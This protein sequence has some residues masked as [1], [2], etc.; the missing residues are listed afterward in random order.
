MS[1]PTIQILPSLLAADMGNLEAASRASE[2]AGAD[3]LHIDVMDGHFVPNLSMGPD[4]VRMARKATAFPLSVHLMVTRPDFFADPFLDAGADLLLIH[5]EAQ[6][7]AAAVMKHVRSRGR[8]AGIVLNPET[9]LHAIDG[10]VDLADEVLFMTVHPGFGGQKFI[11]TQLENIRTLRKRK[12][13]LDISVDGGITVETAR[14]CAE[15]GANVF[16]AGTSIMR[17]PDMAAEIKKMR[18]ATEAALKT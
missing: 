3:G 14:A 11:P 4:F 7:D 15:A 16:L 9:P 18:E 10:V 2:R 6:A 1:L 17:A 8:R 13:A 12:P 5:I